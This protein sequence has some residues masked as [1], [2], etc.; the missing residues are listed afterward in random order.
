MSGDGTGVLAGDRLDDAALLLGRRPDRGRGRDGLEGASGRI[1]RGAL[2]R[3]AGEPGDAGPGPRGDRLAGRTRGAGP[4][5][6]SAAAGR[7][8]APA[9]PPLSSGRLRRHRRR[10][11]GRKPLAPPRRSPRS[12]PA[13]RPRRGPRT[14][15][16]GSMPSRRGC[17]GSGWSARRSPSRGWRWGSPAPSGCGGM[18]PSV[19]MANCPGCAAGSPASWAS[20]ATWPSPSATGWRRRCWWASC[21]R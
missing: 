7:S 15:C 11:S 8:G 16:L 12:V 2:R 17:R 3:G 6:R 1:G 5:G 20:P 10:S 13:A 19:P 21:G 4:I 14:W 18:T 9:M